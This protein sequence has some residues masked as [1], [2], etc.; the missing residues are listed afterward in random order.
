[1]TFNYL[2][3]IEF[4]DTLDIEDI[5]NVVLDIFNDDGL[6]WIL[7]IDTSLGFTKIVTCGP[8]VADTVSIG[9]F[10]NFNYSQIEYNEKKLYKMIDNFINDDK[11]TVTQVFFINQDEVRKKLHSIREF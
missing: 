9:N 8:F 1:M 3:Q 11:R 6:E 5:G 4:Q 7:S 2:K 10:F